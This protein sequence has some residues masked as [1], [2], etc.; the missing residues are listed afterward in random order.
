MIAGISFM[1]EG[2]GPLASGTGHSVAGL[3][4]DRLASFSAA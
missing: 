1:P 2:V 3:Q 4:P